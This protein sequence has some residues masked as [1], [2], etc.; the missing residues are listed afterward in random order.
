MRNDFGPVEDDAG[1]GG[2][3]GEIGSGVGNV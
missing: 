1:R 3:G 2:A